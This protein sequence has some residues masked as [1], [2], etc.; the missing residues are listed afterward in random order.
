M[1][2]KLTTM[3]PIILFFL[4]LLPVAIYSQEQISTHQ[5]HKQQYGGAH[6][7]PTAYDAVTPIQPLSVSKTKALTKK[8]FGYLPDWEY[9]TA[10]LRYDILSHIAAFDFGVSKTG[11]ISNPSGWPWT[12]IINQA[13]QDG[14]KVIMCAV[15]FTAGQIDTIMKIESVKQNFFTQ[16]KSKIGQYSLDGINIDFEGLTTSSQGTILNNFMKELS[17][18]VKAKYPAAEISYAGPALMRSYYF[19]GLVAACD[20]IFIMGYDFYGSWSSQ[21]GP[22]APL[23]GG[24]INITNTILTQYSSV[25]NVSPGKLFLGVPYYGNKWKAQTDAPHAGVIKYMNSTRFK[26]DQAV[27]GTYGMQWATDNQTPWYRFKADTGYYQIWYDNDSSLGLKYALAKSK[28][29]GGVGMWALGYDGTRTELWNELLVHF[30][31]NAVEN[32]NEMPRSYQ[33]VSNYPNPFNPS[34]TIR[35]QLP[36]AAKVTLQVFDVLGKEVS[37]LVNDYKTAGKHEVTFN[38]A[39]LSSGLYLYR[40]H[41]GGMVNTG[42]MILMK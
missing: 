24:S 41:S 9:S 12:T 2:N 30:Q 3:K 16:V 13:H 42:K 4:F 40:L 35:Y 38:G 10:K 5:L 34:T 20:Y 29:L 14:V 36:A 25:I 15:N 1:Q 7:P 37:T 21:T 28:N 26:D 17:D 11:A 6:L 32:Q 22:S 39:G 18:T 23:Y 31:D 27:V 8:V 33:T 19:P